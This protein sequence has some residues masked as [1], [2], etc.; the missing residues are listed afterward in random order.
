MANALHVL[1]IN[2][3]SGKMGE[4]SSGGSFSSKDMSK[5]QEAAGGTTKG[6]GV[7]KYKNTLRL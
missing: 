5:I 2:K 6:S 3:E 1:N 4:S 7:K